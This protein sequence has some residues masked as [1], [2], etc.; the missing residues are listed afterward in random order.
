MAAKSLTP[1][2]GRLPA[3]P[4][5][6]FF[7]LHHEM[8]RMFDGMLGAFAPTLREAAPFAPDIDVSESDGEIRIVADLPGVSEHDI[9]VSV[10]DD[11]L[12]ITG[13]KRDEREEHGQDFHMAERSI[14][15]FRRVLTLPDTIDPEKISAEFDKG[16]LRITAPKS[17]EAERGRK[18]EVKSAENNGGEQA[19]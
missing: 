1:F 14:G 18:I 4:A 15:S 7:T 6:P 11:R 9:Q 8:N 10:K 19:H 3:Y 2:N 12:I 17:E 13:Q 5:N 16:V